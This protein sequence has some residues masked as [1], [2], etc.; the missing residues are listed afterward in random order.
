MRALEYI[1]AALGV[2]GALWLA[3]GIHPI[4]GA[5]VTWIVSNFALIAWSAGQRAYGVLGMNT[6][7]LATSLLGAARALLH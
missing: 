7:Y 5:W 2:A 1:G 6:I 3:L 4:L